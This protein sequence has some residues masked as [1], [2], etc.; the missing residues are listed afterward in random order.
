MTDRTTR[1]DQV[2]L[3]TEHIPAGGGQECPRSR[4]ASEKRNGTGS[5][6]V[7]GRI[8]PMTDRTTR[9]DQV[10]LTTEH[11]PAGGGQECPR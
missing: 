5:A 8:R 9:F 2:N 3:T 1:F 4:N 11:I 7:P 10:N 6:A